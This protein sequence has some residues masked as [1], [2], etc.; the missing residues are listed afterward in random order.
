MEQ[1][2]GGKGK[3]G[4]GDSK[5]GKGYGSETRKCHWCQKTGHLK[6]ACRS[7]L[8]GKPKVDASFEVEPGA[9]DWEADEGADELDEEIT[10]LDDES[11]GEDSEGWDSEDDDDDV[12]D[13]DG[14]D[15][16]AVMMTPV[17]AKTPEIV[18]NVLRSPLIQKEGGV[19]GSPLGSTVGESLTESIR[20]E[21]L[22]F[23]EL[24]MKA[25]A[26]SSTPTSIILISQTSVCHLASRCPRVRRRRRRRLGRI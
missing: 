12:E 1:R 21:Q 3:D 25:S 19:K 17:V 18:G 10:P 4:K 13:E 24:M 8:A 7:F 5:D 9:G 6:V 14:D 16:E 15:D 11:G 26:T 2:G 23:R 22:E 20:R